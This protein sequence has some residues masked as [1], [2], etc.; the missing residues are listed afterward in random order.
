MADPLL[1]VPVITTAIGV[2]GGAWQLLRTHQQNVTAFEDSLAREYREL[3][4][5][6]PIKAFLG[7]NLTEQEHEEN[8]DRF[9]HYFDLSNEQAFL[10]ERRRVRAST[11]K[12]WKDGIASNFK[13]P[14]FRRAWNEVCRRSS[15]FSELRALFP[16]GPDSDEKP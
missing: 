1:A 2:L 3:A 16:P 11:W 12:F 9:Y 7:E 4:A 5:S 8:L 13:R 10:H 14:A 15:D 6:L